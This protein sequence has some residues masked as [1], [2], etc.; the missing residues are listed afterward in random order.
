M[1]K[2][3]D[4]DIAPPFAL[5]DEE[6]Y[7]YLD[8]ALANM[9]NRQDVD[10]GPGERGRL[11]GW[12]WGY[13]GRAAVDMYC[14]TGDPQYAALLE[15]TIDA[16][17]EQRDDQL[18]MIDDERDAV[19][20]GWGTKYAS[21]VRS[22]EITTAGLITLPMLEY[23]A[24][25][26]KSWVRD[27][28]VETLLAFRREAK[29]DEN[30]YRYFVHQ[31][32]NIVEALNHAAL[33][34]AALVKASVIHDDPWL[35]DTALGIFRYHL[36]FIDWRE[37]G[38]SWPYSPTPNDDKTTLASEALWKAAA[39]IELPIALSERGFEDAT[40][41]LQKVSESFLTHPAVKRGEL[42]QFLG[43]DRPQG[44]DP[45]RISGGLT[46]LLS[47]FLQIDDSSLRREIFSLM[48][49]NSNMFPNG[50]KGGSRSM[51]MAWCHLRKESLV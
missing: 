22:N 46:G 35:I 30:G 49:K 31:T 45:T 16:L 7:V 27:A 18:A 50:W 12:Y 9:V 29:Q 21:G 13:Y 48:G 39:T 5:S 43:H 6:V 40:N 34:G 15:R 10:L 42:P 25:S 1:R 41:L 33:Y 23:A 32:Q 37:G 4:D 44:V 20:P 17:L 51:I 3:L 36:K 38:I 14:V 47:S 26:G 19:F 8:R 11:Y 2:K 28:A 24:V